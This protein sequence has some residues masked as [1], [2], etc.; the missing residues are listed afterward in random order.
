MKNNLYV[1][2]VYLLWYSTNH[3]SLIKG[4]TQ[5]ALDGQFWS[6][7]FFLD[8]HSSVILVKT[9]WFYIIRNQNLFWGK[10]QL[11]SREKEKKWGTI[12]RKS[13]V[14]AHGE[15]S[16]IESSHGKVTSEVLAVD[17]TLFLWKSSGKIKMLQPMKMQ[18]VV[19]YSSVWK[20][21]EC[22]MEG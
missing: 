15:L 5:S 3:L 13:A 14:E 17:L 2:A 19:C 20:G 12:R 22:K 9:E 16:S 11:L 8:L 10:M 6:H 7:F 1:I 21:E 18:T 4:R